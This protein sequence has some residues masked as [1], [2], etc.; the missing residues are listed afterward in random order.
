[1]N[2]CAVKHWLKLATVII[3]SFY[4][5][6]CAMFTPN[7]F[8]KSVCRH[9]SV[10]AAIVFGEHHKVRIA[11]GH[12]YYR[13]GERIKN[14]NHAQ[15]QAFI[16]NNWEWLEVNNGYVFVSTMDWWFKPSKYVTVN[17]ALKWSKTVKWIGD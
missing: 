6:S 16:G 13:N 8:H 5:S 9:N 3:I 4:C 1:M 2:N 15:A 14:M 17:E 11:H 7:E 10:L 12:A